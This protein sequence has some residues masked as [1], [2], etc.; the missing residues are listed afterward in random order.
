MQ[1]FDDDAIGGNTDPNKTTATTIPAVIKANA[2][3]A[4]PG[5]TGAAMTKQQ[6]TESTPEHYELA[7]FPLET[8]VAPPAPLCRSVW[9]D[10]GRMAADPVYNADV[11][12]ALIVQFYEIKGPAFIASFLAERL[13]DPFPDRALLDMVASYLERQTNKPF[14]LEAVRSRDRRSLTKS[15]NDIALE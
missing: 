8:G 5:T 2:P 11:S 7:W 12:E 14:R 1:D 9:V 10:R 4:S 13:R 3:E 15:I 6:E